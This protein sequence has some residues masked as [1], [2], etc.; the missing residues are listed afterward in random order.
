MTSKSGALSSGEFLRTYRTGVIAGANASY[1]TIPKKAGKSY[2]T[3]NDLLEAQNQRGVL[4]DLSEL[5]RTDS[6][7]G[8]HIPGQYEPL[9]FVVANFITSISSGQGSISYNNTGNLYV[10][11]GTN[12]VYSVGRSP[13]SVATPLTNIGQLS[14]AYGIMQSQIDN[15]VYIVNNGNGSILEEAVLGVSYLV[16]LS[17]S[18][19]GIQTIAQDSLRGNFYVTKLSGLQKVTTT[20]ITVSFGGTTNYTGITYA[21]NDNLYGTTTNG[22]YQI[23]IATGAS[24][25]IYANRN[26]TGGIIQANDG[27]LYVTSVEN[28][29]MVIQVKLTGSASVFVSLQSSIIPQS[30]T[31]DRDE[32]LYVSCQNGNIYQIVVA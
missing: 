9:K 18:L 27:N 32:Y 5:V 24:S 28:G 2:A 6:V 26:L 11:N 10:T 23:N 17:A 12:N 1:S 8:P 7:C 20:G 4:A 25:Q 29:G 16:T 21:T 15:T 19:V 13:G 14:N 22:I 31:Q 3:T 30:I